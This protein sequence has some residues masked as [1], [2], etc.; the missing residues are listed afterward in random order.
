MEGLCASQ[1]T[2]PNSKGQTIISAAHGA[3]VGGPGTVLPL[4]TKAFFVSERLPDLPHGLAL[5]RGVIRS[6]TRLS[7]Q[8][9]D[10]LE[11][12]LRLR[13]VQLIQCCLDGDFG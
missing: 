4:Q 13:G 12:L 6:L 7:C 1:L 9:P 5:E 3:V 11:Y 2:L 8:V 10:V